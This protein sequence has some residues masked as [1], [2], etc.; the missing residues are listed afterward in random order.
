MLY[1]HRG[2]PAL[3]QSFHPTAE[4]RECNARTHTHTHT[5][6][7]TR[8]AQLDNLDRLQLRNW[9]VVDDAAS[10]NPSVGQRRNAT[11]FL[12]HHIGGNFTDWFLGPVAENNST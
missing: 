9:A 10:Q 5:H 1:D 11:D 4:Y 12:S 2:P 7:H 3:S 6:T 8:M